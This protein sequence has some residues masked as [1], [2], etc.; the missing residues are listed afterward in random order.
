MA[1]WSLMR[2]KRSCHTH[3]QISMCLGKCKKIK[4]HPKLAHHIH[5]SSYRRWNPFLFV[6]INIFHGQGSNYWKMFRVWRIRAKYS[7][8]WAVLELE[9]PLY[10]IHSLFDRQRV[11]KF[12]MPLFEHWM[13]F[14]SMQNSCDPDVRTSNKTIC[15][16][17]HLQLVSIWYF[18]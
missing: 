2:P 18:R 1:P 8:L 16:S 3:G 17:D 11:F 6:N 14:R 7:P 15:L 13:E 5:P 12:H 10:W 9:K 4:L